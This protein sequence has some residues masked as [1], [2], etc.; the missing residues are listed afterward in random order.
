M[1]GERGIDFE[2]YLHSQLF[3]RRI[4][5]AQGPLD[6]E[7]ATRVSAQLLTLEALAAEPIRL[8]LASPSGDIG[9][10]LS[11][12]DTIGVLGVELTAVA[13]GEVTGAAVA[14][15]AAAPKRLAY[16]HARFGLR[17]PEGPEFKGSATEIGSRAEDYLNRHQAFV[18][19][20]AEATG[21]QPD[22]IAADL[23]TGRYLTADQAVGYGLAD[24]IAQR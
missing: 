20:L 9:A 24:E 12:V 10:A 8:H 21:R 4:V 6:D 18:E 23:R 2:T 7:R 1:I 16:P 15:Y 11:L 13:V 17:E 19:V 22:A 3:E 14:A 5:L